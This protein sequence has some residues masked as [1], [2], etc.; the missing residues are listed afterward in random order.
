M[1]AIDNLADWEQEHRD[2]KFLF[3]RILNVIDKYEAEGNIC[4]WF[5][6]SKVEFCPSN[7]DGGEEQR[8]YA[9]AEMARRIT[10][11]LIRVFKD[12]PEVTK[13]SPDA[14]DARFT[15]G[16]ATVKV[17]GYMG[18]NCKLVKKTRVVE[19]KPAEEAVPEH[20]EEYFEIECPDGQKAAG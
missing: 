13:S 20:E 10:G 19:Y 15:F 8:K 3:S 9:N 16:K 17:S 7:W 14:L 2:L 18:A 11:D 12:L 4:I 6:Q 1:S 5:L